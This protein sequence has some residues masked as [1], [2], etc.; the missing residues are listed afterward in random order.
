MQLTPQIT[1]R[2]ISLSKAIEANI[3]KHVAKLDEFYDRIT[4]CRVTIEVPHRH[5]HQGNLYHIRID[6][7]VPGGELVVKRDPPEHQAHEDIYVA[8]RD[9][10]D[11]A[12]RQLRDYAERQRG[13]V[14]THNVPS[15]GR[16]AT[17]FPNRGYGFIEAT[18]G[19][20]VYFHQNSPIDA[21]FN[22]LKVGQEVRFTEEEGDRGPQASTVRVMGKHHLHD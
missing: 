3:S 15:H 19:H 9:A 12:E 2:N 13:E 20:E 8:I 11:S 5:H 21:A 1:L 10:F 18:D 4:N 16:I 22:R 14:K 17:L 7:T 6:L